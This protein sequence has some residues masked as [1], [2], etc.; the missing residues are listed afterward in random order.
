MSSKAMTAWHLI[1]EV[2]K[3]KQLE[4]SLLNTVKHEHQPVFLFTN[5]SSLLM[6]LAAKIY[7]Y[8]NTSVV[9]HWL[10]AHWTQL[11]QV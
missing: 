8:I 1:S 4:Q 3:D 2:R 9:D 6:L 7:I 11:C 5:E 10:M